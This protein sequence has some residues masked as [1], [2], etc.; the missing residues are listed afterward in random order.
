MN[1]I[2]N[3]NLIDYSKAINY[4]SFIDS[5]LKNFNFR[6]LSEKKINENY[7]SPH[8]F[9]CAIS[10][11]LKEV[12]DLKWKVNDLS[13]EL[14]VMLKDEDSD[15]S[16]NN[17]ECVDILEENK[18]FSRSYIT[19]VTIGLFAFGVFCINKLLL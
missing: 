9:V 18:C 12:E 14:S 19:A 11:C 10:Q 13:L 16:I 5:N 3:S 8:L 6:H 2:V 1:K 4:Q 17:W 15:D 7:S